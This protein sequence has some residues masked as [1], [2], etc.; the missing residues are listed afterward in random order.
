LLDKTAERPL[1][2][3]EYERLARYF[4]TRAQTGRHVPDALIREY[5]AYLRQNA[6]PQD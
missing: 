2:E 6:V 1:F 4:W 5:A 3:N